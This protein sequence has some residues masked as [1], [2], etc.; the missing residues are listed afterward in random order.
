MRREVKAV[1]HRFP[2]CSPLLNCEHLSPLQQSHPEE[3]RATGDFNAGLQLCAFSSRFHSVERER[4]PPVFAANHALC[5]TN[6]PR[7]ATH[8]NTKTHYNQRRQAALIFFY[9]YE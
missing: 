5:S 4:S 6:T 8:S 9:I 2:H 7:P 3:L 1:L